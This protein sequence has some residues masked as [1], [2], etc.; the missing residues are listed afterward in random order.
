MYNDQINDILLIN[1]YL[2]IKKIEDPKSDQFLIIKKYLEQKINKAL[3]I[4]SNTTNN[5]SLK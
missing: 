4:R 2:T 5:Y 3:E 1:K